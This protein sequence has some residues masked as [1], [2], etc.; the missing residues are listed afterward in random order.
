[1]ISAELKSRILDTATSK[2]FYGKLIKKCDQYTLQLEASNAEEG[3]WMGKTLDEV[4]FFKALNRNLHYCIEETLRQGFYRESKFSIK[5]L[6]ME[7]FVVWI[8]DFENKMLL[9]AQEKLKK[10]Q[11]LLEAFIDSIPDIIFY[12]DV[13]R[14]YVTCNKALAELIQKDKKDIIGKKDSEI[15]I[16]VLQAHKC[17]EFDQKV[18]DSK[19]GMTV[20]EKVFLP[21]GDIRVME[22]LKVPFWSGD[23][24]LLGII[25]ICRDITEKRRAEEKIIQ[26]EKRFKQIFDNISDAIM[27]IEDGKIIEVNDAYEQIY[28]ESYKKLGKDIKIEYI[29]EKVY[30]EDLVNLQPI[31]YNQPFQIKGR[32]LRGDGKERWVSMKY[33]AMPD[34][35][36]ILVV[37]DVT[38]HMQKERE[39]ENLRNEFFANL[40]HEFKTPV[41]LIHSALQLLRI[42][43]DKEVLNEQEYSKCF[44][45]CNQNISRLLKL[46]SNLID[47][48]K[49]DSGYFKYNPKNYNIV[50]VIE[51]TALSVRTYCKQNQIEMI[52]DTDIE[53]KI[54]YFDL[55][56]MERILLNLLS[57]AIKYSKGSKLF[58]TV[59]QVESNI[60]ITVED[61]GVGIP[62]DAL[63]GIFDKFSQVNN[64]FT[65]VG[66]GSGLG[67]YLVKSFINMHNGNIS[68]QS[69]LGKGTRFIISLPDLQGPDKPIYPRLYGKME[70]VERTKFEF[71]DLI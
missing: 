43:L 24:H 26:S 51:D 67:L 12:K 60:L 32:I 20:E 15:D 30:K 27:I 61:N 4:D 50:S 56:L 55:E 29:L 54:V 31:D 6:S 62:R 45:I 38:S 5:Q 59:K 70:F 65:K 69:E 2:Y 40:S 48:T 71:S 16:L 13:N 18:I 37:T 23:K 46:I 7:E 66:E 44:D 49:I 3:F 63:G 34:G 25:G 22:S 35:C 57:N 19:T 17:K 21:S 36:W 14:T 10:Q 41:N 11:S 39:L 64:R 52:F 28:R 42:K 53:E 68:V 1:M 8:Y 58:V 9:E 47:S 33:E